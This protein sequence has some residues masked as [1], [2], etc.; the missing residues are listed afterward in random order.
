[1]TQ[2]GPLTVMKNYGNVVE[3]SAIVGLGQRPEVDIDSG[4]KHFMVILVSI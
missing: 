4:Q 3:V 2:T 1:M